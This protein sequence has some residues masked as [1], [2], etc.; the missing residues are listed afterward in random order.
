MTLLVWDAV[1]EREY[2]TGVSKGI[3]F[4]LTG[5]GIPWNGLT[6]VSVN[7]S[8][9]ETESY[10]YDGVKYFDATLAEDFE[11]TIS[12]L[13]APVEFRPMEGI[14]TIKSGMTVPFHQRQKFALCWTTRIGNDTDQTDHGYK[15]HLVYNAVV[16]PTPSA[17]QTIGDV[18]T[19]NSRQWTIRA[20]PACYR[21]A[22]F[23]FDSRDADLSLLEAQLY[24][25]VLPLCSDLKGLVGAPAAAECDWIASDFQEYDPGIVVNELSPN[26]T[27][28]D[29]AAGDGYFYTSGLI[30]PGLDEWDFPVNG[31]FTVNDSTATETGSGAILADGDD[32]TY[33]SQAHGDMGF[34]YGIQPLISYED[35]ASF[36]LHLRMSVSG[37]VDP[38]DPDNI[39]ADGQIFITT[40]ATGDLPVGGFS[41][42][43]DDGMGFSI[44]YVDGSI[45]DYVIPLN[46]D[47]WIDNTLQDVV[48]ALTAGAFLNVVGVTNNNPDPAAS[49]VVNI[50]E[51]TI[52][53]LDD[54]DSGHHIKPY[55]DDSGYE[56]S[57]VGVA[58][59]TD[60]SHS[61]LRSHAH[62][63]SVDFKA[64]QIEHIPVTDITNGRTVSW[65]YA[66][67]L[68]EVDSDTVHLMGG[69]I[70]RYV[71]GTGLRVETHENTQSPP[72]SS[73]PG[74]TAAIDPNKWYTVTGTWHTDKS[75]VVQVKEQVSQ[76]VIL[77]HTAGLV[78]PHAPQCYFQAGGGWTGDDTDGKT[79]EVILD[80][81]RMDI[82][83]NE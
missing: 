25:G 64:K 61:T 44:D 62:V 47:P 50:Y 35:G 5:P 42:G 34:T 56:A 26:Y 37:D 60:P 59:Y 65:A 67:P 7:V 29:A 21:S 16:N 83:C 46:M 27:S 57:S 49:P 4:P 32:T 75:Y 28:S 79:F 15:I 48:D 9:G 52:V 72:Y 71:S 33:V 78:S 81:L 24:S 45:Q 69:L 22:Y 74:A 82:L 11:A 73:T 63:S 20:T 23:I 10:Y 8:G 58:M 14:K 13:N 17:Y 3:L 53:M 80:N 66:A 1:G 41:D 68:V 43:T 39:D 18:P 77:T 38:D 40:D 70:V 55:V 51:A 36:E 30:N 2:E 76:T 6:N 54:T 31:T 19:P 12:A